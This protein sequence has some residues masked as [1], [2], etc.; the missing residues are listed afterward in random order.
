MGPLH[1]LLI[2]QTPGGQSLIQDQPCCQPPS[3]PFPP[4]PGPQPTATSQ[5][6]AFTTLSDSSLF[7][8]AEMEA[9]LSE[10]PGGPKDISRV[11]LPT[12]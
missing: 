12:R 6:L 8:C 7:S 3:G 4:L 10:T 11:S 2:T 1:L 5:G 9:P